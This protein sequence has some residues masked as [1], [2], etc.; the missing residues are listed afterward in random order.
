LA[1]YPQCDY[2]WLRFENKC[3]LIE[4][5]ETKLFENE[6]SCRGKG[7]TLVTIHSRLENEFLNAITERSKYF[8]LGGFRVKHGDDVF[9]W[10]DNTRFDYTKWATNQQPP[11][12]TNQPQTAENNT[13]IYDGYWHDCGYDWDN[14]YHLC[15][16]VIKPTANELNLYDDKEIRRFEGNCA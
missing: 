4:K 6:L 7:A 13:C 10:F 11:V 8:W 3:F 14:Y 16:K 1:K 5:V 9:T 2:G 15:Q 12:F